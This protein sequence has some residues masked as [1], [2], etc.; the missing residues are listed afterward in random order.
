[1]STELLGDRGL[2][3]S[4]IQRRVRAYSDGIDT[5]CAQPTPLY[6]SAHLARSSLY[7]CVSAIAIV[8]T[9][10]VYDIMSKAVCQRALELFVLAK[11]P[12]IVGDPGQVRSH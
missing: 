11:Q 9:T 5:I 3:R 12:C 2:P 6:L 10:D 7:G 8:S 4:P 1:M